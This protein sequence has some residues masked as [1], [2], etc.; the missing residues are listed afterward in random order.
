MWDG[1]DDD[2][3]TL[4]INKD[5]AQK[6]EKRE[7][8]KELE[9]ARHKFGDKIEKIIQED[10]EDDDDSSLPEDEE[11]ELLTENVNSKFFKT[12]AMLRLK[13][14]SIYQKDQKFFD[15]ADFEGRSL[16]KSLKDQD[17]PLYYKDLVR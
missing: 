17:K 14:P 8:R 2:M 11:A 7:K 12:M 4:K 5:Y 9:K 6:F 10:S 1:E 16:S 13:D 15:D 3:N